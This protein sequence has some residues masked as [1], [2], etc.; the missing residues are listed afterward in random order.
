MNS[1]N[2]C[3][4]MEVSGMGNLKRFPY[5]DGQTVTSSGH[6][7]SNWVRIPIHYEGCC[8]SGDITWYD[9]GDDM[10]FLYSFLLALLDVMC[11]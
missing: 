5:Q 1:S 2:K 8:S 4:K 7:T 3:N 9:P 11:P 10:G 6:P